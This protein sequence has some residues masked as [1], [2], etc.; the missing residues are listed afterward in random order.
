M[1]TW[2]HDLGHNVAVTERFYYHSLRCERI[3]KSF[4]SLAAAR[5]HSY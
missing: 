4:S 1:S 2:I 5:K 3:F